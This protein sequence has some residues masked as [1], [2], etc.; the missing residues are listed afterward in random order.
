MISQGISFGHALNHVM[1]GFVRS[2]MGRVTLEDELRAF[3]AAYQG[4]EEFCML[5]SDDFTTLDEYLDF[6]RD[7]RLSSS[8]FQNCFK[9]I[10]IVCYNIQYIA[11][12]AKYAFIQD[13]NF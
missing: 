4:D 2:D 13:N 10:R 5:P 8:V 9:C 3:H 6:S 1:E 7:F 12:H 11:S